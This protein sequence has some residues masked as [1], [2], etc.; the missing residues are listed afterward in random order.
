MTAGKLAVAM[1][2]LLAAARPAAQERE[3]WTLSRL[4]EHARANE[5]SIRAARLEAQAV[6]AEVRQASVWANPRVDV[7]PAF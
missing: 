3:A 2:I 4:L 6:A 7:V 5:P 1:A